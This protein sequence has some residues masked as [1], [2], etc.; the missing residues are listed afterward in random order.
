MK[1][2]VQCPH[3]RQPAMTAAR[4][5]TLGPLRVARC[6]RCGASVSV[7]K[8]ALLGMLPM[9]V[10]FAGVRYSGISGLIA[11]FVISAAIHLF[12][13]ELVPHSSDHSGL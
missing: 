7:S 5:L 4:K 1:L 12:Y 2:L 10:G 11:C 13:V 8:R 3:C 6:S 9:I